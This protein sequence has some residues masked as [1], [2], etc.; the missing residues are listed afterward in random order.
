MDEN[1][2]RLIAGLSAYS[3]GLPLVVGLLG[4]QRLNRLQKLI[5]WLVIWS[6]I[7]EV[8]ALWTGSYLHLPNL[9]LVHIFTAGQFLLL[10]TIFRQRLLVPLREIHFKVTLVAFAIAAI[11]SATWI[12][13]LTNFNSHARSFEAILVI[14][15]C[16]TY[17]YQ[18]LQLLDLEDL[19]ND[20]LFWLSTGS[21]VY[22]SASLIMFIVSNYVA[23]D[24]GM[25]LTM[26]AVHAIL[27]TFNNVFLIIALWVKPTK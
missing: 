24:Q 12:D 6:I 14:F 25:S 2:A 13:G 3:A 16:L 4:W 11:L 18:R 23:A 15:F 17:F 19:E 10:W 8:L 5:L 21:L 26:W 7:I 1:V 27:N 20:P 22:F 9:F